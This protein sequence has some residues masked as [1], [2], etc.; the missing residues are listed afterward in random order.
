M[1]RSTRDV[2]V[3]PS[4]RAGTLHGAHAAPFQWL[5]ADAAPAAA[6]APP[7]AASGGWRC[8]RRVPHDDMLLHDEGT[9][10]DCGAGLAVMIGDLPVRSNPERA[11]DAIRLLLL[12]ND[13]CL[14]G[15]LD[16]AAGGVADQPSVRSP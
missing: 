13:W 7:L 4:V 12:S 3:M 9:G 15:A 8:L 11:L 2:L 6:Q 1:S 10:A 14:A 16:G 5:M